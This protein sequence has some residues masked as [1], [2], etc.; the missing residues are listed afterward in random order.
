MNRSALGVAL[1]A[2][3][4]LGAAAPSTVSHG[5][6]T[7]SSVSVAF[8]GDDPF[9]PEGPG[10]DLM[11]GHCVACHSASMVLTQPALSR[12]QWTAEVQKM[13]TT[14]KAPV[15]E[16]DVPAIV[17]YLTALSASLPSAAKPR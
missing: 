14:Y 15:D 13:R 16:K 11:N 5:G 4:S 12:P 2:L 6:V 1:L 7:L 10:G 17:D 3:L 8:P 9:F